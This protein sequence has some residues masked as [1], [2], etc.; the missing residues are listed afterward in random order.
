MFRSAVTVAAVASAILWFLVPFTT[1]IASYDPD[2]QVKGK[3]ILVTGASQGIGRELALFAASEGCAELVLVARTQSK[4]EKVKDAIIS[5]FKEHGV[6]P[7]KVHVVPVDLSS[8]AACAEMIS[9]AVSL[10]NGLDYLIL[11]HITSGATNFGF[12]ENETRAGAVEFIFSVN[13]FSY[14]WLSTAALP[15]LLDSNG[16]LIVVSSLAGHVGVPKSSLYASTKHALHGF[17]DSLRLELQA[18]HP[19]NELSITLC[20]IGATDTEGARVA[21]EALSKVEFEPANLAS[22]AIIVGG[23][24]RQLEIFHPHHKLYPVVVLRA[25][26]PQLVD[27]IM[28]IS[29]GI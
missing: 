16:R 7:P 26:F 14:I 27:K 23:A 29:M 4:L 20:A 9:E 2:T 21:K 8:E 10:M 25:I 11:N 19:Q 18:T 17:F 24:T 15:S 6:T 13:T 22:R 1:I 3:R 12:Y 28:S 5:D